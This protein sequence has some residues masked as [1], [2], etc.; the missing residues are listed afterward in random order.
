MNIKNIQFSKKEKA[1]KIPLGAPAIVDLM[2]PRSRALRKVREVKK[3]W[4]FYFFIVLIIVIAACGGTFALKLESKSELNTEIANQKSLTTKIGT[5]V[6]IDKV[7]ASI[8]D[9]KTKRQTAFASEIKWVDTYNL[10]NNAL[11]SGVKIKSFTGT[12]GG[13]PQAKGSIAVA[14]VA[15]ISSNGPIAYSDVLA[16]FKGI[17]G[18]SDVEIGNLIAEEST[19]LYNYTVAFGFNETAFTKRFTPAEKKSTSPKKATGTTVDPSK[20]EVSEKPDGSSTMPKTLKDS[21]KD[22]TEGLPSKAQGARN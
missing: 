8:S 22:T 7:L 13:S 18:V 16:G 1:P 6:Q 21:A 15:E 9:L 20:S 10:I 2:P 19:G 5:H 11:P 12:A 4:F 3:K 17:P 14:F